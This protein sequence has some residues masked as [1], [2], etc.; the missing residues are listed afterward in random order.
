VVTPFWCDVA[1]ALEAEE[2]EFKLLFKGRPQKSGRPA[3]WESWETYDSDMA[4]YALVASDDYNEDQL[5]EWYLEKL[6]KLN[7]DV[8]IAASYKTWSHE[9]AMIYAQQNKKPLGLW[10]ERPLPDSGLK[11]VIKQLYVYRKFSTFDFCLAIGDRALK[12][13]GRF[14][15]QRNR[16]FLLPY[17]QSLDAF[18]PSYRVPSE[19]NV[20]RVLFAG[21]FLPRHNFNLIIEC[22]KNLEMRGGQ[23]LLQYIFSGMGPEKWRIDALLDEYPELQERLKILDEPLINFEERAK[24][25]LMSDIFLYPS[26]YSGWG[27]VIP[28]AMAAGLCVITTRNVEA[29]R[30]YV[31]HGVNGIFVDETVDSIMDAIIRLIDQK[32]LRM[33]MR[34]LA[35]KSAQNGTAKAIAMRMASIMKYLNYGSNKIPNH[36]KTI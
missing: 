30:Y 22:I 17:G 33:S 25:Y 9:P 27:L 2:I 23:Y 13:Y 10:A 36:R 11:N 6:G 14:M 35:I 8:V 5:K 4:N 32:N 28:E 12:D 26:R 1:K 19:S 3:H 16:A 31:D 29:A 18:N 24:H 20:L 15:R 7:P 34:E 21:Q